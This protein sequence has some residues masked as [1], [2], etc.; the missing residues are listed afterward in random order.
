MGTINEDL[1]GIKAIED[2]LTSNKVANFAYT[3]HAYNNP[4]T[5]ADGVEYYD[6]DSEQNIPV[7]DAS[8]MDVN[9]T[10]LSKGWRSQASSITRMLMNHFL[11]RVSYNLNKLNDNVSSLLSTLISH[12]GS[13]DG[14]AP[15][16]SSGL[17]DIDKGGTNASTVNGAR[18]N[19][20]IN[21][22][23]NTGD[24][25]NVASGGTTKF[26]TGG[27]YN[28]LTSIAPYFSS[29][30][31]YA[32][33][34]LVTYQNKFYECTTAH[35][36]GA[37]NASHFT[38]RSFS[39][40]FTNYILP[41]FAPTFS[42]STAYSVGT[43][44]TYQNRLYKCTTAHSAGAWNASHFA[45]ATLNDLAT[46]KAD[47]V[48][49]AA[50]NDIA[51]LDAN[52][53]LK[54][55]GKTLASF[56]EIFTISGTAG[57]IQYVTIDLTTATNLRDFF[58]IIDKHGNY[59][60]VSVYLASNSYKCEIT[61]NLI[62]SSSLEVVKGFRYYTENNHTYLVIQ[63]GSWFNCILINDKNA[64]LTIGTVTNSD[65]DWNKG[66]DIPIVDFIRSDDKVYKADLAD[67]APA[68]STSTAY[69]VGDYV[70]YNGDL[71]HCTVAHTGA[72][73]SSHFTPVTV[74]G[75]LTNKADNSSLAVPS[76][77]VLHY[78]FDD[79]PDYPDGTA[80]ERNLDGDT[81]AVAVSAVGTITTNAYA[82]D[83][84][85]HKSNV[86][87][88]ANYKTNV[89]SNR[90][91]G[92][93]FGITSRTGLVKIIEFNAKTPNLD[94]HI[95]YRQTSS[96]QRETIYPLGNSIPIGKH[97]IV[98][99]VPQNCFE[100]SVVFYSYDSDLNYTEWE[101]TGY[102]LG[103]GSY[104]TPIIDNANGQYQTIQTKG[105]TAIQCVSG[106]GI[107]FPAKESGETRIKYP[108][109]RTDKDISI[110]CWVK[111]DN[112]YT[113]N[114]WL[115]LI[116]NGTG[117]YDCGLWRRNTT[118]T[119]VEVGM[120]FKWESHNSTASVTISKNEWHLLTGIYDANTRV[121]KIY[122]DGVYKSEGAS[123]INAGDQEITNRNYWSV[124]ENSIF[125]GNS[126]TT[127][128][129]SYYIDDVLFFDRA[130]TEKEVVALYNNKANT[131]KYYNLNNYKLPAPPITNGSYTLHAT[132]SG[133]VPSY[134]WL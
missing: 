45:L 130:L 38:A 69:A 121:A 64:Q 51:L 113:S 9:E 79:V 99:F 43:F 112:S 127:T 124:N 105:F 3:D 116:L 103:N 104:S 74:G 31:A 20:G 88:N 107:Y 23:V 86:N 27:A 108:S 48:S 87:G 22:V 63:G 41:A 18:A 46:A 33:G 70:T 60:Q 36:A 34:A 92:V 66:T 19:L 42:T 53:N 111:F 78:S 21:N 81:Y 59:F 13:A 129:A 128:G 17:L 98:I 134:S 75:E 100:Y 90:N 84:K 102:Y 39:Y 95:F 61:R 131:P 28:L 85:I 67:L 50:D 120:I 82:E 91:L 58:E 12:I 106:K 132:V 40:V 26:T 118:D 4:L 10:V 55:S 126:G 68:F 29:S 35:S 30:T 6:P 122:V 56:A 2:K 47:K 94:V 115:R 96:S 97:R 80:I 14:I 52:G 125:Q 65:T 49:G 123:I 11:G 32:V 44:V 15:L 24:S 83:G 7:A 73:N 101:L 8:V 114:E 77:A 109:A 133:G 37:W 117:N 72:W 89:G 1:N 119:S 25:A 62:F 93:Y 71:Y 16:N 5:E 57:N 110:S 54:D 76:D